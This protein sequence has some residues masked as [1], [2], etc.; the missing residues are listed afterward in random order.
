ME[1]HKGTN[2]NK[3]TRYSLIAIGVLER[4]SLEGKM[5]SLYKKRKCLLNKNERKKDKVTNSVS[6]KKNAFFKI[7]SRSFIILTI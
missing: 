4:T 5:S 2:I 1:F 3:M 7:A 6:N